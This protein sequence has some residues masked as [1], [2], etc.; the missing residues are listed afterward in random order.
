M[1]LHERLRSLGLA[2]LAWF[3]RRRSRFSAPSY[4]T[5]NRR[6]ERLFPLF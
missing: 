2:L 6:R 4:P 3:R 5:A 1:S